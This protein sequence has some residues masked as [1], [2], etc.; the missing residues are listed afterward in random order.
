MSFTESD[1]S[2]HH[3][4]SFIAER[5]KNRHDDFT[6]D[7]PAKPKRKNPFARKPKVEALENFM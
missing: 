6:G 5:A 2:E 4:D 7:K 3:N 1:D